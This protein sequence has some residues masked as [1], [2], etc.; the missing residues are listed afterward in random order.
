MPCEGRHDDDG[1]YYGLL[2]NDV[3]KYHICGLTC[4]LGR[5]GEQPELQEH[6]DE[7][8]EHFQPPDC[9]QRE[10]AENLLKISVSP[11]LLSVSAS[12]ALK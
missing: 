6:W 3:K 11:Q 10:P 5:T 9:D 2:V 1:I 7:D 4:V 8:A 12:S